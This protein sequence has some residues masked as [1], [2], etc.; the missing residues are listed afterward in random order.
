MFVEHFVNVFFTVIY[1]HRLL[2]DS[3][4]MNFPD[5]KFGIDDSL[6]N[7]VSL[8]NLLLGVIDISSFSHC[9]IQLWDNHSFR[10]FLTSS[11]LLRTVMSKIWFLC[12]SLRVNGIS[13]TSTICS[14]GL[15]LL[16]T[17]AAVRLIFDPYRG[18]HRCGRKSSNV[19]VCAVSTT[20]LFFNIFEKYLYHC[21]SGHFPKNYIK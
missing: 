15:E 18:V 6:M 20:S 8:W 10:A 21:I 4:L 17:F 14:C 12:I 1:I 2:L 7:F 5:F 9:H 13:L 19:F 11:I 3:C 16:N